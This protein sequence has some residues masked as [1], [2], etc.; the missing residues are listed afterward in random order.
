MM[1][2][3]YYRSFDELSMDA[4]MQEMDEAGIDVAVVVG[5]TA[6]APFNGVDN[7]DVVSLVEGF[8][9]RFVGFGSVDVSD[10]S[11]AI[12]EIQALAKSGFRGIAFDNPW[13]VPPL[14]DDD[15]RL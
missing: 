7:S 1:N 9:D 10:P 8:P 4:F 5:R 15:S 2:M 6:P 11:V 3:P 13:A 12:N 14:Y